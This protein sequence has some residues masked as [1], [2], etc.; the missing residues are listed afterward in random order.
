MRSLTTNVMSSFRFIH[1][2]ISAWFYFPLLWSFIRWF[3]EFKRWKWLPLTPVYIVS[4]SYPNRIGM[5]QNIAILSRKETQLFRINQIRHFLTNENRDLVTN[6]TPLIGGQNKVFQKIFSVRISLSVRTIKQN[7]SYKANGTQIDRWKGS[8]KAV[9]YQGRSQE[10]AGHWRSEETPQIQTRNGRSPRNSTIPEV[11][12]ASYSQVAIPT[13]CPWDR[14]RLQDRPAIPVVC[15]YG[16]ARS[17]GGLP[18]WPLRG[19]QSVRHPRQTSNHHA[20]G[21]P[22]GSTN[23]R[24]TCLRS[25]TFTTKRLF[26]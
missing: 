6:Q 9:G 18:G 5:Y 24:R 2:R 16:S 7:G 13:S 15:C 12:R 17:V 14:P 1:G 25:S 4:K 3:W 20:Q 23:P 21:H 10:R 19:H 22:V 8:P 11:D 26:S